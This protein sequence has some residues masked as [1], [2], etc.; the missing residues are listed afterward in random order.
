M[1]CIFCRII[2]NLIPCFK[3]L[4]TSHILAFM[5]INPLS[6]GHI[7]IVPKTHGRK[8]TDCKDDELAEMMPAAKRLARAIGC[9]DYNLL[10]NNGRLAHQE[11]EHVHLHLIPKTS[12]QDGLK[13]QWDTRQGDMDALKALAA[14]IQSRLA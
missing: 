1:D 3:L 8:L 9:T 5:D 13:M 14:E 4:D 6:R 2:A 12:Q 10:Q 7:L 11:V